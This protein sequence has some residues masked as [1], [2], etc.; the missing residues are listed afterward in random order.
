MAVRSQHAKSR[1]EA[2]RYS[3]NFLAQTGWQPGLTKTF[4][5]S[6]KYTQ[7]NFVTRYIMKLISRR[8]GGST[9]TSRDHE[10]TDWESVERF[11]EAFMAEIAKQEIA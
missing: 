5:G 11:A 1:E 7:Y 10:Y 9:D 4:A 2:M 8:E 6:V 3:D